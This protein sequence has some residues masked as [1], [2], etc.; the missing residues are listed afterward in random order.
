MRPRP[1]R[2]A[3]AI[4]DLEPPAE[5]ARIQAEAQEL[6]LRLRALDGNGDEVPGSLVAEMYGR[7]QEARRAA[8]WAAAASTALKLDEPTDRL[9][10]LLEE[11]PVGSSEPTVPR[12]L[13]ELQERVAEKTRKERLASALRR[14]AQLP[15]PSEVFRY[16]ATEVDGKE[17]DDG[18]RAEFRRA[19]NERFAAFEDRALGEMPPKFGRPG[20]SPSSGKSSTDFARR[21]RKSR[22]W[23]IGMC[24][25]SGLRDAWPS[26][27]ETLMT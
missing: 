2:P 7:A 4:L 8:K 22:S 27:S 21:E 25:R 19:I 16:L 13:D 17:L 11:V 20:I 24:A 23:A 6:E 9:W 3:R 15:G 18:A 14:I 1:S 26:A 12:L 5:A 10:K